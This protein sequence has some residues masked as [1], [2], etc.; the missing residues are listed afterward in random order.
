[1]GRHQTLSTVQAVTAHYP[2]LVVQTKRYFPVEQAF[3]TL[4]CLAYYAS[5]RSLN[6]GV[7]LRTIRG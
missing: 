4:R 5:S 3:Y 2:R 6:G 7:I 1:M